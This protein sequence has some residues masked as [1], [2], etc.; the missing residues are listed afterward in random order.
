MY[1]P[2]AFASQAGFEDVMASRT[3][4]ILMA[5]TTRSLKRLGRDEAEAVRDSL[6]L[7]AM[8]H[9]PTIRDVYK[10]MDDPSGV[11][12]FA[13]REYELFQPLLA[14][15]AATGDSAVVAEVTEFAIESHRGQLADF[16]ESSLEHAYL[17][18]LSRAVAEDG[19]YR[20]DVLLKAFET[21]VSD[22][23]IELSKPLTAKS[24]GELLASLGLADRTN[25]KRTAD[26]KTRLYNLARAKILSVA[27]AY[28]V[29]VTE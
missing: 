16:S 13:G 22:H 17:K 10:Q 21:F 27:R 7:S 28:H 18:F 19:E 25:K 3:V 23:D 8:T 29:G 15:A 9:A 12:P 2:R 24:Q 4:K 11:V 26:R 6:F 20:G 14:I 1:A 5:R